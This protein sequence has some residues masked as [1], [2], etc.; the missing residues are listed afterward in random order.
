M[1]Q[2]RR[3]KMADSVLTKEGLTTFATIVYSDLSLKANKSITVTG[4]GGLTGGGD[5]STS[6][7]I[8]HLDTAGYKHIPSGGASGQYLKYSSDGTAV[9]ATPAKAD[10]G[11]GNVDN[12]AD[13]AKSVLSAT[14]L[15][16]ARTITVGNTGK[17]FNGTAAITF[18]QTDIS[19]VA[20]TSANG[21]MSSADKSSIDTLES[22]LE[23]YDPGTGPI[24]TSDANSY[25]YTSVFSF[26]RSEIESY[27]PSNSVGYS[28]IFKSVSSAGYELMASPVD[29]TFSKTSSDVTFSAY[30]FAITSDNNVMLCIDRKI[31]ENVEVTIT[32]SASETCSFNC[33]FNSNLS[34]VQSSTRSS[35]P[36]GTIYKMYCYSLANVLSGDY[37]TIFKNAYTKTVT[38]KWFD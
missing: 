1:K 36:I 17:S 33:Y 29:G 15:T 2:K 10:V 4:T 12:T 7:T 24:V 9:W 25:K 21:W 6:R 22:I 31:T 30:A 8:S 14:K 27:Y 28:S 20:T 3:K 11:L 26:I 38:L 18:A 13:S 16:T 34:L 19:G 5:L 37:A 35:E 32:T 23:F